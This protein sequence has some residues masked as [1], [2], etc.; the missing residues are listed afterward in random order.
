MG[1][2]VI[3][4]SCRRRWDYCIQLWEEVGLLYTV[5]MGGVT[6]IADRGGGVD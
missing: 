1:V 6:I 2:G 5:L 4:Y 3:V